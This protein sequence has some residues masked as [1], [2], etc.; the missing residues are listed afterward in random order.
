MITVGGQGRLIDFNLAW[1]V[2]HSSARWTIHTVRLLAST[3][4]LECLTNEFLNVTGNVA[5]HVHP[6]ALYTWKDSRTM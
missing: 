6:V 1:G 4:Y 3:M 5:I 2:N